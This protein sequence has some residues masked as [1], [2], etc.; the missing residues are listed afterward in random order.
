MSEQ[1][2]LNRDLQE[3]SC[4]CCSSMHVRECSVL[5]TIRRRVLPARNALCLPSAR[6]NSLLETIAEVKRQM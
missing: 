2:R 4:E 3:S 1:L 6:H 5:Y